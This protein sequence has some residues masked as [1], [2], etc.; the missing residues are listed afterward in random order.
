[1]C[2]Q[3]AAGFDFREEVGTEGFPTRDSSEGILRDWSRSY[4]SRNNP[5]KVQTGN[6]M[7]GVSGFSLAGY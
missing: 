1:M 6:T 2:N 4:L 7:N 5:F 3:P